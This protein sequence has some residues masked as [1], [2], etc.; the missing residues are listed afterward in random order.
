VIE[1]NHVAE[2]VENAQENPANEA[3]ET[4]QAVAENAAPQAGA[5]DVSAVEENGVDAVESESEATES[6]ATEAAASSAPARDADGFT[7]ALPSIANEGEPRKHGP[8]GVGYEVIYVVRAGDPQLVETSS[9]KVRELIEGGEGAVDNVRASEVRRFAYPIK[10]Q[11][12]GVY[13]VVNA[14]FKPE[15]TDELER[16]F[17]IDESILR[18]MMLKEDR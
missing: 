16:Y 10:K 14:R 7:S 5:E 11:N 1:E 12:E 4:T 15:F 3:E 2:A 9:Q 8:G 17:K 13:V 18:H 6:E